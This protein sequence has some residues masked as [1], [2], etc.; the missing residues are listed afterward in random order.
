MFRA[1]KYGATM[2]KFFRTFVQNSEKLQ[3]A[4]VLASFPKAAALHLNRRQVLTI[5]NVYGLL[6]DRIC[7]VSA[8]DKETSNVHRRP[9]L[10]EMYPGINV[11][12][13]D[14]YYLT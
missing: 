5:S 3:P 7:E 11:V 12:C 13:L 9:L 1:Q 14:L 6:R 8:S 10:P 2:R 4:T